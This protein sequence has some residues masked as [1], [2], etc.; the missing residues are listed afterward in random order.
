MDVHTYVQTN[1]RSI[2]FFC[3]NVFDRNLVQAVGLLVLR[4][5]VGWSWNWSWSWSWS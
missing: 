2:L 3:S 5:G 4:V 1:V